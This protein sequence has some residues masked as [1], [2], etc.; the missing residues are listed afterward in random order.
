MCSPVF[1]VIVCY[2][3]G[4]EWSQKR[5]ILYSLIFAGVILLLAAYPLY[6]T[7]NPTPSCFDSRQ[8]GDEVGLDCGGSCN[9]YCADQI[10]ELRVVW[11]KA[12][13]V[14]PGRYDLGAYVENPNPAAGVKNV[15]YTLRMLDSAGQLLAEGKGETEVAPSSTFLL[16]VSNV[17]ATGTPDRVDVEFSRADLVSWVKAQAVPS[18][19][20]SKNQSLKNTDTKPRFDATLLNTDLVNDA[21][22]ASVGA[23]IYDA[24]R[25]PVAISQTYIESVPK[26]GTQ[27]VFFTW[28]TR[29]TKHPKGGICTTPVDTILA[30]DRSGSM[31]VGRRTPP[32]PLTTAKNAATAYVDA[33]D[34]IDKVGLV[35]FATTPSSPMDHELSLD[36][37]AVKKAVESITIEKGSLQHTN[38]G[39]ALKTAFAEFSSARHTKN[40]KRVVVALTDGDANRPLD[41]ANPKNTAY[42]GE[43]AAS[44]AA[45]LRTA[46]IEVYA[47]GL[48]K[49]IS[50]TFLRDRIATNPE[51]YFNAPTASALQEVYKKISESVCKEENFITEIV[52]TPRAEFSQ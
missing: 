33:A 51:Q 7:V 22:Y 38:L 43:Y 31:D 32:E 16:F 44:Q 49:G 9:L 46:G 13:Q 4:M 23:I 37:D 29:F 3:T 25:H 34:I 10:K 42:A 24:A 26:G 5:R 30:F 35:S 39:D 19:L 15:H 40:A 47:I 45:A 21:G 2:D 6:R 52:V 48:G 12:F 41:E 36:H 18:T 8:N 50:E 27:D 14:I 20:I 17:S 11:S 28:P 1:F